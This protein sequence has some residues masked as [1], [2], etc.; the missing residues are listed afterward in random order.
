MAKKEKKVE[1]QVEKKVSSDKVKS[2][3]VILK[4]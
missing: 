1:K 3:K 4:V 2:V